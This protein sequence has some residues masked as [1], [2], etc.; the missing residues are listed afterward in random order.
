MSL[1]TPVMI[2]DTKGFWDRNN[3][4][5]NENIFFVKDNTK[6]VWASNIIELLNNNVLLEKLSVNSINTVNTYYRQEVFDKTLEEY[7]GLNN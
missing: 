7:I 1:G 5:H 3:F 2:T 4:T 6:E